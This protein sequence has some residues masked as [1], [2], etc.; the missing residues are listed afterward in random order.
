MP[1]QLWQSRSR[2]GRDGARGG[3]AA[4]STA[5]RG[6]AAG[7]P[8]AAPRVATMV[9]LAL[10][11]R[12]HAPR[13]SGAQLCA[14]RFKR[15]RSERHPPRPRPQ[16]QQLQ[17]SR[18][19][20]RRAFALP[21]AARAA[22]SSRAVQ[23]ARGVDASEGPA[24]TLVRHLAVAVAGE[25]RGPRRGASTHA[26]IRRSSQGRRGEGERGG[27]ARERWQ[28]AL[29]RLAREGPQSDHPL[30]SLRGRRTPRRPPRPRPW[31]ERHRRRRRRRRPG[32]SSRRAR[33]ATIPLG[34]RA[35]AFDRLAAATSTNPRRRLAEFHAC[36]SSA[37]AVAIGVLLRDGVGER[38]FGFRSNLRP[39][40][41]V[42]AAKEAR[43]AARDAA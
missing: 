18:R 6:S 31:L 33:V 21:P 36:L 37:S 40:A 38:R 7:P 15:P 19:R 30:A 2:G 35:L 39:D 34:A 20:A 22:S 42:A 13:R 28:E 26:S 16:V 17:R 29:S 10:P 24:A 23:A 32:A 25:L 43:K 12:V 5:V 11:R 41:D 4:V 9:R 27:Q 8:T 14:T 3:P 1:R